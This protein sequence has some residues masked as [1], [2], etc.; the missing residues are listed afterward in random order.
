MAFHSSTMLPK[1][2]KKKKK[3]NLVMN[4]ETYSNEKF[5]LQC[6]NNEVSLQKVS[7]CLNQAGQIS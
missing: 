1:R 2:K 3:T 7:L 6:V 4:G 5:Y